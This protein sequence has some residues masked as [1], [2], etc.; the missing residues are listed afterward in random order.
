MFFDTDR[1]FTA[2]DGCFGHDKYVL[3]FKSP[4]NVPQRI[5][6]RIPSVRDPPFRYRLKN[7]KSDRA[8]YTAPGD[9]LLEP[10]RASVRTPRPVPKGV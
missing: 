5:E 3:L 6:F 8:S 7:A 9:H 1:V 4:P 10:H 2:V